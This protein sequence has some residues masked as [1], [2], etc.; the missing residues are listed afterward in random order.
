MKRFIVSDIGGC[1]EVDPNG[2]W[3]TREEVV[4]AI[5]DNGWLMEDAMDELFGKGDEG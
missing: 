3:L 2:K 4:R 1:V 5:R